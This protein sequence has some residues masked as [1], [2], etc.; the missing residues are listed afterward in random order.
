VHARW[1]VCVADL[2][3]DATIATS[4]KLYTSTDGFTWTTLV[5]PTFGGAN[6]IAQRFAPA[7]IRSVRGVLFAIAYVPNIVAAPSGKT[8][9]VAASLDGGSTWLRLGHVIAMAYGLGVSPDLLRID[10][11]PSHVHFQVADYVIGRHWLTLALGT[12]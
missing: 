2:T 7:A 6:G 11:T 4:A 12:W 3:S 5:A 1:I 10:A 9:E 8:C